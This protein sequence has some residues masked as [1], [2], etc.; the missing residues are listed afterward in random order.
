MPRINNAKNFAGQL[1]ATQN[2]VLD[3]LGG[4]SG[5]VNSFGG[6]N[7]DITISTDLVM[8]GKQLSI[9]A[10]TGVNQF[11]KFTE[12]GKLPALDASLLTG[13][14]A[15]QLT[16]GTVPE[17]RLTVASTTAKGIVQLATAEE[18]TAGTDD[19]KAITSAGL[20]VELDKK[21]SKVAG[22]ADTLLAGD[23]S[24]NIVRTTI[25]K[26]LL[27]SFN[28]AGK[29]VQV[30][31]DG[32]IPNSLIPDLAITNVWTIDASAEGNTT[33]TVVELIQ[34]AVTDKTELQSG[35][36][37]IITASDYERATAVA[38]TYMFKETVEV[39]N[40]TGDE[41]IKLYAPAG[42]VTTVNNVSPVGGNITLTLANI[43]SSDQATLL[44]GI[45]VSGQDVTVGGI[46]LA[47]KQSITDIDSAYKA[48][49]KTI[50][51][52]IGT[53]FDST[54][55]VKKAIDDLSTANSGISDRVDALE[56]TVGDSSS[57]LVKDVADNKAAIGVLNGADTVEGSVAKTVKDAVKTETDRAT[58]EEGKLKT[59]VE[60]AVQ[61]VETEVTVNQTAA[62]TP[63]TAEVTGRIIAIY[64]AEGIYVYPDVTYASNKSTITVDFGA[65]KSETWIA[66]VAQAIT[67]A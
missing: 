67:V 4:G 40:I 43:I 57:G 31:V 66:V 14:N 59:A 55:T 5:V 47:T 63:A 11:L 32:K 36:T 15:S 6:Q 42:S 27:E 41:Y 9:N 33:K 24:G 45:T 18:V 53:G 65:V 38:G 19:T 61:F 49:D 1:Y 39:A 34:A 35:D 51:D 48:A 16:S 13:L 20:K 54:N 60:K 17:A 26:S 21:V 29:L 12:A 23:A 30:S 46:T 62:E 8:T 22:T 56:T 28:A 50:Q 52:Q 3:Q 64:D 58:A 37:I 7:G 10:G 25:L 44:E 2:W